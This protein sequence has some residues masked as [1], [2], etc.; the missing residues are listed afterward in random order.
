M[1]TDTFHSSAGTLTVWTITYVSLGAQFWSVTYVFRPLVCY[2]LCPRVLRFTLHLYRRLVSCAAYN[3]IIHYWD[4]EYSGHG[5]KFLPILGRVSYW[6]T[7]TLFSDLTIRLQ[8]VRNQ[9][10]RVPDQFTRLWKWRVTGEGKVCNGL[11]EGETGPREL[12]KVKMAAGKYPHMVFSCSL[13]AIISW[14]LFLQND[15]VC[16]DSEPLI[17]LDNKRKGLD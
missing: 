14:W 15:K 5:F 10:E 2:R 4:N 9:L 3:C 7:D 6:R 1:K 17:E 13:T 12:S 11:E 8:H 16:W